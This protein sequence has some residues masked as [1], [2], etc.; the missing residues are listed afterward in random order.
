MGRA[1]MALGAAIALAMLV[2]WL[3]I[4]ADPAAAADGHKVYTRQHDVL[5]QAIKEGH[6]EGV[7]TGQSADLFTKQFNSQ[8]ALLVTARVLQS[9][10]QPECKRLEMVYTKQG[11]VGPNG[12]QDVVMNTKLNYCT[13][14]RPPKEAKP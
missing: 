7:L 4:F 2:V 13:D 12:P 3:V 8:G 5:V 11:V 14:G 1:N 10:S 6:A 9:F